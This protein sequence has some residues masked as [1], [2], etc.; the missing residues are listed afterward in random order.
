MQN[1]KFIKFVNN[2]IYEESFQYIKKKEEASYA[3]MVNASI[4]RINDMLNKFVDRNAE[5][6]EVIASFYI[7]R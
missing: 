4:Q 6:D 3:S 5:V 7:T 2:D 1:K